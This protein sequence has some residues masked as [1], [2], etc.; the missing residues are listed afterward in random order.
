MIQI[1]RGVPVFHATNVMPKLNQTKVFKKGE[2]GKRQFIYRDFPHSIA[3]KYPTSQASSGDVLCFVGTEYIS[4]NSKAA[5]DKTLWM[6]RETTFCSWQGKA[7]CCSG[8][9]STLS[10]VSVQF[11]L[12][13]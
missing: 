5:E 6:E 10:L 9:F 3:A 8:L 12:L 2:G 11:S 7:R 13:G 1:I 4:A